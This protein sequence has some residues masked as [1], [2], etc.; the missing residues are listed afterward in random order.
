MRLAA[1]YQ[2]VVVC[3]TVTKICINDRK[4]KFLKT[5]AP[6][7]L[8]WAG[9]WGL[10]SDLFDRVD[11]YSFTKRFTW[12]IAEPGRTAWQEAVLGTE[13][14]SQKSWRSPSEG[15]EAE[16]KRFETRDLTT[17]QISNIEAAPVRQVA[18]FPT[19]WLSWPHT[20]Q[21][22]NNFELFFRE[23]GTSKWKK[24]LDCNKW[25][26]FIAGKIL[27]WHPLDSMKGNGFQWCP[28]KQSI[29]SNKRSGLFES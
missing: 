21:S 29:D 2:D 6:H 15:A 27:K 17:M 10:L 18:S 9:L 11:F 28:T 13:A 3:K 22:C 20:W 7:L 25:M 24:V 16:T 23:R 26:T 19:R 12:F 5:S 14:A 8:S 1:F 4:E